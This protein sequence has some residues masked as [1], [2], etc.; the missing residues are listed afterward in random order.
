MTILFGLTVFF[1]FSILAYT[2]S[3]SPRHIPVLTVRIALPP[4][5]GPGG[6]DCVG[7]VVVGDD[8]G[9]G[10]SYFMIGSRW[11]IN[12]CASFG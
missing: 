10:T 12:R 3:D 11:G 1:I 8:D 7:E 6:T 9:G 5:S 2:E 4:L